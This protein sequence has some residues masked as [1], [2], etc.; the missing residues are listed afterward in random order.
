M[1]TKIH[2]DNLKCFKALSLP[3]GKLTLLTGF[4]AAG[5]STS[6][7]SLLLL[8]QTMRTSSNKWMVP[9]NGPLIQLGTIGDV[10]HDGANGKIS[11]S[12][13]SESEKLTWDLTSESRAQAQ[14]INESRVQAHSMSVSQI[15]WQKGGESVSLGA[16][17]TPNEPLVSLL[18]I[19][20]ENE[21][22]KKLTATIDETIYLS[23]LRVGTVDIQ[24]VP[25]NPAQINADVGVCGE[26]AAWWYEKYADEP[27]AASR[28]HPNE[29]APFLRRQLN[30]WLGYIFT[31]AQFTA[32]R[33]PNSQFLQLLFRNHESDSWRKPS[34][35]GY[36]LSYALPILVAGLTAK[37]GQ[38][39]VIDS[40]EAHLH[41]RGQSIMGHFLSIV[42]SSGVQV[43]VET[44]SDH[45]LNGIRLSVRNTSIKPEEVAIHFFNTRP[46]SADDPAHV[47]SPLMDKSGNLSDW[48]GGFFDQAEN[49]LTQLAGWV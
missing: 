10:L 18:P 15:T 9:L 48:P 46:R 19:S 3:L 24:Q 7:Q 42:A 45:V 40:P 8:T 43:I 4:N 33:F 12:I 5:K 28:M 13:E 27:I 11:I 26:F 14:S 37:E 16:V 44:H 20:C 29:S 41:P 6:I 31:G 25:E 30:A 23:A 35:I 22:L 2:L 32:T 21:E 39:L 36:G 17:D 49:D 47:V 34:N 1:I 38:I